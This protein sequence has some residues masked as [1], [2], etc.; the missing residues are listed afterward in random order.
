MITLRQCVMPLTRRNELAFS[1]IAW[2]EDVRIETYRDESLLLVQLKNSTVRALAWQGDRF[3]EI[4][5]PNFLLDN[6]DLSTVTSIPGYGFV[7]GNRFV[8]I[9]TKLNELPSPVEDKIAGMIKAK[10]LLEVR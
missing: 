5:L 4:S 6:F 8:K 1:E 2:I 7:S 9:D 3:Q 10:T